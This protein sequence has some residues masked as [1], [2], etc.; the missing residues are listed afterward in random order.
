[1]DVEKNFTSPVGREENERFGFGGSETQKITRSKNP[2]IKVTLFW[3][4]YESE[5]ITGVEHYAWT[6]HRIQEAGKTTDATAWQYQGSHR[7][8]VGCFKSSSARQEK[9][10][11][12][13]GGKDSEQ[14]THKCEMNSGEGNGKPLL[15]SNFCLGNPL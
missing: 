4:R 3:P 10:A 13:G 6:S 15:D 9:M 12:A 8:T 7:P 5:R 11:H 2:P 1:M 14:G